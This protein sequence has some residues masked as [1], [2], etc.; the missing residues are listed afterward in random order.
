MANEPIKKK[1][2]NTVVEGFKCREGKA[3]DAMWDTEIRGL[4]LR[5]SDDGKTRTYFLQSR[6]KGT[7]Q[8]RL[9][10]IGRHNDPWR[11]DDVRKKALA[12]K[13][14]MEDG[15]DPVAKAKQEQEERSRQKEENKAQTITLRAVMEHY[16]DNKRT[17]HGALRPASKL[18][19]QRHVT[20]NL[21]DWA[22]KPIAKI[23]REACLT[24][25]SELTE[26]APGQANQCMVNLRALINHAREMFATDDGDYPLF[27][28]N[29]VTRMFKLRK[30]NVEK[31]K[32]GRIALDRIGSVW[33][34]L[35]KRRAEARTV[36]DRTAADWVCCILLT[37][38][39]RTESGSLKWENVNLK[40][41]IFDLPGD[42]VKNH[43]GITLPMSTTLRELLTER[44]ALPP[45][46]EKVARR[47]SAERPARE[48][49]DYVFPSWGKAGYITDARAVMEAVSKVAGMTI[50]IHDLRRTYDDVA[51]ECRIDSDQRRQLLNH[52]AA[53]VHARHYSNNPKSLAPAVEAVA[54][55]ITGQGAIAEAMLS[56]SNVLPFKGA[57]PEK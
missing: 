18:D 55:W 44:K 5:V 51:M 40:E 56:G 26:R 29:P 13:A 57:S 11:I 32:D 2:T 49:S 20:V 8:Q 35:Q 30:P 31:P 12:L 38:T 16:L 48:S 14:Q 6:V 52:L 23:T 9:I 19:I 47:R 46:T 36:D 24:R 3:Q 21:A 50:T 7:G 27:P 33:A 22:D 1:L 28:V 4:C 25:F 17:K 39:R 43:H 37:G 15:I 34:M 42:V 45:V 41:S 10:K 54:G 53:D